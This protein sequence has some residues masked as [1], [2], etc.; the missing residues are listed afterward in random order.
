M[1]NVPPPFDVI[2]LVAAVAALMLGIRRVAGGEPIDLSALFRSP[3][4]TLPWPR[5][6]QEEEPR[7]WRVEILDR[8]SAAR[9]G[10]PRRS[11]ASA[12]ARTDPE[13]VPG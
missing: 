11:T 8:R 9:T 10:S 13:S 3:A 4:A 5:G 1:F 6:V 12:M 2:F 7:S